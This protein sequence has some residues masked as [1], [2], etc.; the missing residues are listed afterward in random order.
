MFDKYFRYQIMAL[1]FRGE[2]PARQ[3]QQL[4]ECALKRDAAKAK[5]ILA[6]HI[7]GCVEHALATDA[8]K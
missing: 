1:N 6:A 8:L 3:H 7:G 2:E 5:T 4:L